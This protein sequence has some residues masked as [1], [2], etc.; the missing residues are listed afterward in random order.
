MPRFT[1]VITLVAL[2]IASTSAFAP[3]LECARNRIVTT[4]M[5]SS[6]TNDEQTT[7]SRRH[8]AMSSIAS[9]AFLFASQPAF[10]RLEAVNRPDL[11]PSEKGLN[12]IQTEKFLTSGQAKRLDQLL[13][14]VGA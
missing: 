3:P 14:V 8:F 7:V 5:S 12:V 4:S 6:A 9:A 13:A 2:W 1:L 11:L 10:A